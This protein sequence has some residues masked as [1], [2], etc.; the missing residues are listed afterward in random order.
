MTRAFRFLEDVA[1]ADCAFEATGDSL[2]ELFEA[3]AWAVVETMV[4][5]ATVQPRWQKTIH[6]RSTNLEDLLFEWVSD[7]VYLKDLEGVVFH[8]VTAAVDQ[9]ESQ[10]AWTLH[11][12]LT[13]EPVDMQRHELRADVKAVTKHLYE[14]RQEGTRWIARIVLD[15]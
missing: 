8:G 6:R 13:G 3:A 9:V 2:S 12:T 5:P 15:V 11:G 4:D 1:L 14:L 7:F 10:G